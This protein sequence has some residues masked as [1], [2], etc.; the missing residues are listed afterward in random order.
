MSKLKE[1]WSKEPIAVLYVVGTAI[2]TAFQQWQGG[3]GWNELVL[4]VYAAVAAA[5]ARHTV[6]APATVAAMKAGK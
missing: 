6:Y 4:A 3:V 2:W 1:L 5:W